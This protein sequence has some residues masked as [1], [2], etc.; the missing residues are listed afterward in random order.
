MQENGF[1]DE[2]SKEFIPKPVPQATKGL[3]HVERRL[4]KGVRKLAEEKNSQVNANRI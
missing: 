1:P 3:A 4:Y 2:T